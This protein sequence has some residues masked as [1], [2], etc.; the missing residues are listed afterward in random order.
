MMSVKSA[1]RWSKRRVIN[2]TLM[3]LRENSSKC[4]EGSCALIPIKLIAD[5]CKN[6]V[7]EFVPELVETLSSE[8]N[9]DTVCTVAGL[10]NSKRIDKLL[11]KFF[12]YH[13]Q[14]DQEIGAAAESECDMCRKESKKLSKQIYEA[15]KDLVLDK[16]LEMCGAAPGI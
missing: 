6:L 16:I 10:C 2:S 7:D 11:E 9:P 8:M 12:Y 15:D 5:E 3:K 14:Q 1:K 4:F 13:G